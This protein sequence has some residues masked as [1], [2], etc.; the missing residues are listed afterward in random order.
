MIEGLALVR[1]DPRLIAVLAI[2]VIYNMF[3]WP[4]TSMVPVIGHDNLRLGAVGIGLLASMGGVGAFCGAVAIAL[5]VRPPQFSRL[6]LGGVVTYMVLV[7][8]F[9]LVPNAAAAGSVLL[10]TGMA[11]AC[12]SIM[13]ATL[14]YLAA[15]PRDAQPRLWRA[16]GVHRHRLCWVLSISGCSPA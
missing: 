3:G 11:N 9:A 15:P 2:T 1:R 14:V 5:L 10:L 4:F 16:V 6:Y 7:P 13:Q 12:F 8:I